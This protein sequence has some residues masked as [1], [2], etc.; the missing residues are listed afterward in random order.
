[1]VYLPTHVLP[2]HTT[3]QKMID[4]ILLSPQLSILNV[5]DRSQHHLHRLIAIH[6]S[7]ESQFIFKISPPSNTLLLRHERQLLQGEAA[8]LLTLAKST[9]PIPQVLKYEPDGAQLGSPF[10]LIDYLPGLKYSEALPY[11]SRS[12]RLT[13]E[14]QLRSLHLIISQYSSPT[15]GLAGY[16]GLG[17]VGGEHRSWREA[18]TAMLESVMQDGEDMMVNISYFD[19]R[20]ALS[21]WGGC[22]DE[23]TQAKLVVLGL[24]KPEN[25]LIDR[26]TTEVVGLLDFGMAV[27][28]DPAMARIEGKTDIRSLL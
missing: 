13:I 8:A 15:F 10:L 20:G 16:V 19:I 18:F 6:L 2:R 14:A 7:N 23:V 9:L 3:F 25:V 26:R 11:L 22:L 4:S 1:M 21:R 28:G 24:G 17:R 5:E 12:E 27:W